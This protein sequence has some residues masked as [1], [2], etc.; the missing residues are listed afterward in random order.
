MGESFLYLALRDP[1]FIGFTFVNFWAADDRH[2]RWEVVETLQP[3]W[4]VTMRDESAF[5]PPFGIL[6]VDVPHMHLEIPDEALAQAYHLD[7]SI[8]TSVG[9]FEIWRRS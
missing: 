3:D 8:A 7:D 9:N 6:S 2:R 1:N 5:T 4:I